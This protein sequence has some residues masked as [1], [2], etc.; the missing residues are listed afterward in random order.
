MA[1]LYRGVAV[2]IVSWDRILGAVK[3]SRADGKPFPGGE[4][5]KVQDVLSLGEDSPGDIVSSVRAAP[6]FNAAKWPE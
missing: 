6:E 2:K 4:Y 3:I 1:V 5:A